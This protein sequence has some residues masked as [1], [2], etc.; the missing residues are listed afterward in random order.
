MRESEFIVLGM[1]AMGSATLYHLARKGASPLGIEQF[2]VGHGLGSS[3]GHSRAFRT[4]YHDPI[5]TTL[6]EASVPLWREI[7]SLSGRKVL[8]LNGMVIFAK[9]GNSDFERNL[10]VLEGLKASYELLT[11]DEVTVRFPALHPPKGTV[12]C[13][14]PLAGFL[15]ANRAVG[16]HVDVARGNGASVDENVRVLHIDL[17]GDRPV[18]ETSNGSYRCSRLVVAGG[19]WSSRLLE[20]LGLPLWV[21]RQQKFYFRPRRKEDYLPEVLPVFSN[22]DNFF[23]GF[24]YHGAGIKV[25]DDKVG[26]EVSPDGIDRTLDSSKQEELRLW[27]ETIMPGI[28]VSFVEGAT[29]MYTLTPDRDFIVGPHP[30]HAN[31][32][33]AA[34]FS[35]HGFKFSTLI[36]QILAGLAVDGTTEHPIE[37]FRVDR[38]L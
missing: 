18:L 13:F 1:G 7:E 24:P 28:D 38:F 15:D 34:G 21:S 20:D 22:Y 5:Y 23:Y 12:A 2:E 31:V 30:H 17:G 16:A 35:G 32:L 26:D 3:Y 36:G 19:P 4:F 29:C 14:T 33:I 6:A 25:A 8:T 27:L 10:G 9:E 11:P 37:R